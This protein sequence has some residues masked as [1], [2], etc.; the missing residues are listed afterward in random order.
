MTRRLRLV[1]IAGL[2]TLVVPARSGAAGPGDGTPAFVR[3]AG[4]SFAAGSAPLPY[5][6]GVNYEGP[7]G[8]AWHMWEPGT[9]SPSAIG[10]DFDRAAQAGYTLLRVFVQAPLP[11]EVLAG[12]FSKLD[13]VVALAHARGLRLLLTLNDMHDH[14]L[15]RVARVDSLIAAHFAAEPAIF[16]Y[17]VENEPGL[18]QIAGATY[19]AGLTI[20]LQGAAA[21][22]LLARYTPAFSPFPGRPGAGAVAT[23]VHTPR[24][25]STI[26]SLFARFQAANPDYP[27]TPASGVWQPFVAACNASLAAYLQ[28]QVGAI[29]A[30]DPHHLITAGYNS[31]FWAGL[32]ANALLDFRS[33][34]LYPAPAYA[35]IAESLRLFQ[36]LRALGATPLVLEEYGFSSALQPAQSTAVEEM[37]TQLA[38]RAVGGAGDLK[39]MLNDVP[40]GA[41]PRENNLG[42]FDASGQPKPIYFASRAASAYFAASQQSGSLTLTRDARSGVAFVY[43]APDAFAT[44]R[45][46]YADDRL[47]YDAAAGGTG[48]VWLSWAE[49]GHLRLLATL[50]ATVTVNL[51]AL[52]GTTSPR[53]LGGGP[54][55]VAWTDPLRGPR[56]WLTLAL[57]PGRQGELAYRPA[58]PP[59]A[60]LRST[61]PAIPGRPRQPAVLARPR[62]PVVSDTAV[63]AA[64]LRRFVH[65]YR[66][67]GTVT[68]L[69]LRLRAGP[70]MRATQIGVVARHA[71]LALV[72]GSGPWLRV[73]TPQGPAGWVYGGYVARLRFPSLGSSIP[74]HAAAQ[75]ARAAAPG[76]APTTR[77]PAPTAPVRHAN[78]ALPPRATP[79]PR[80]PARQRP[81][82]APT[83]A[84]RHVDLSRL[85]PLAR[86]IGD[87]VRVR[88]GPR[89]GAPVLFQTYRGTTVAVRRVHISWVQVTFA[90]GATGWI[91]GHYLQLSG[92][93][94]P[95][96]PLTSAVSAPGT[97][98][99]SAAP[100]LALAS[101]ARNRGRTAALAYVWA[102]TLHVRAAPRLSGAV[103]ALAGENTR[104]RL[105]G[106]HVSWSHVRLPNGVEGWVLTHYIKPKPL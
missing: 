94:R 20:P 64:T 98:T 32:P 73:V 21:T 78:A 17:D 19:P 88:W 58:P 57:Q 46:A 4:T 103:V 81:A 3:V 68:I 22:A 56:S 53:P 104:V 1:L 75:P 18:S 14:D 42:V 54:A 62:L 40:D 93:P 90:G 24:G 83:G 100:R 34:H 5:V 55:G 28:V 51:P 59:A 87:G 30:A 91:L 70:S 26:W 89:L 27:L 45:A 84:A 6:H 2:L 39:W 49:R 25:P 47:H 61:L 79:A 38:V 74:P 31:A 23:S 82:A 33:I 43:T 77:T 92:A 66:A 44:S 35:G 16:A 96:A 36:G 97:T 41:N 85:G 11:D 80:S 67:L 12:N 48:Q 15:T 7:T 60:P 13:T 29:R 65:R 106:T 105:L 37:A 102:T 50:A 8:Q 52:V 63:S 76:P 10:A 69:A 101:P 71:T 99:P 9:F 72:G 86:V 95:P